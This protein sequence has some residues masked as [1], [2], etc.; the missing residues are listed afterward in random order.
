MNLQEMMLEVA[1][2]LGQKSEL[3]EGAL[4]RLGHELLLEDFLPAVTQMLV[5]FE[6]WSEDKDDSTLELLHNFLSELFEDFDGMVAKYWLYQEGQEDQ[7]V[8]PERKLYKLFIEDEE[9]VTARLSLEQ[10]ELIQ[11]DIAGT[12][13]SEQT[14]TLENGEIIETGII[15]KIE[16]VYTVKSALLDDEV[17]YRSFYE[18]LLESNLG[19]WDNV[20]GTDTIQDYIHEKMQEDIRVSHIVTALEE[21]ESVTGDWAI[22]LGN[23]ME[24]P[25]PI[26]TKEDLVEALGLGENDLYSDY[27]K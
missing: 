9:A 18:T 6:S 13:Q 2:L 20:N 1:F 26:N 16:E 11:R 14:I 24:T 4:T 19:S 5:D 12:I 10:Y 17:D 7:E 22:W 8:A 27:T 23:S 3:L 15:D 21:N 25:T